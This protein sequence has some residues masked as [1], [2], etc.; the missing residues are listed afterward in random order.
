MK[1]VAISDTHGYHNLLDL[2]PADMII[3][4]G[5]FCTYGHRKDA[6]D[7]LEWFGKLDYKHKVVIAGNHDMCFEKDPLRARALIPPNVHYLED[8]LRE[9]GGLFVYGSP[10]QPRF[11]NWAFNVDRGNLHWKWRNIPPKLDIL[12]THGPPSGELGG[13]LPDGEDVGDEE[14]REAI[15]EKKPRFHVC[16]HIHCGYGNYVLE[17][18]QIINAAICTEEYRPVQKPILFTV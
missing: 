5:D 10:W 6:R 18:T 7:F 8:N 14:L 15:L 4:A 3:H 1:V 17:G 13:I 12:I 2:P 11:L 16:G 9:I